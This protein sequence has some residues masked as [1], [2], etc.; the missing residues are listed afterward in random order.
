MV[1]SLRVKRF[2]SPL[3]QHLQWARRTDSDQGQS[4]STTLNR[5]DDDL[6]GSFW[7][8]PNADRGHRRTAPRN[9]NS[10]TCRIFTS[11]HIS[12]SGII[13]DSNS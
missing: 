3:G 1:A 12:N 4:E 6:A 7:V 9:P 8:Y 10:L 13:I 2:F 5:K 11:R